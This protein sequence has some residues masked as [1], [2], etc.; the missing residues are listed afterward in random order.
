M[1]T[2][3]PPQPRQGGSPGRSEPV[4][5]ARPFIAPPGSTRLRW[6]LALGALAL[7]VGTVFYLWNKF[8]NKDEASPPQ[9]PPVA[10]PAFSPVELNAPVSTSA[11]GLFRSRLD[12]P[13]GSG[14]SVSLVDYDLDG[15][16]DVFLASNRKSILLEN[17]GE[18]LV[19]VSGDLGLAEPTRSGQWADFDGDGDL[20]LAVTSTRR[21]AVLFRR[22]G[23][24]FTRIQLPIS[25][26]HNPEG[27][28]WID[29]DAD[30]DPDL[31]V[32]NGKMGVHL[33]ENEAGDLRDVSAAAGFGP[34]GWGRDNGDFVHFLDF[35]LDGRVDILYA[36]TTGLAARNVDGQRFEA[37]SAPLKF[38][39]IN[40]SQKQAMAMGDIDGDRD[41]DVFAPQR[42]G[43]SLYENRAGEFAV[44]ENS[45]LLT[46]GDR[47]QTAVFGDVDL[48]GDLDL[49]IALRGGGL[50]LFDN[51]NGELHQAT[52]GS[53]F[54]ESAATIQILGMALGDIDGDGDSDLVFQV[55]R[56]DSGILLNSAAPPPGRGL[57][58]TRF[59]RPP[60]PGTQI[61][62]RSVGE[63]QWQTRILGVPT[64][65]GSQQPLSPMFS[66]VEGHALIQ[67]ELTD[68]RR[69]CLPA[70]VS[71]ASTAE[72][73]IDDDTIN[74][75]KRRECA[76]K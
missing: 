23:A 60:V 3:S 17:R 5:R 42:S 34:S 35:D 71:A 2:V 53:G 18:Q 74:S 47:A 48:D 30:G 38:A 55:L 6:A 39:M 44:V 8:G 63:H 9:K 51:R 56:G 50:E 61:A 65:S 72:V 43:A 67:I 45:E 69:V 32:T 68:G 19:A 29:F 52:P 66:L 57:L 59:A 40:G 14:A 70:D 76:A 15:D 75:A 46:L 12:L 36:A 1:S 13:G 27:H 21:T 26:P 25:R 73:I 4:D 37:V 54:G 11:A 28:G 41:L 20:D 22:E 10:S 58:R 24:R 49:V 31:L 64:N 62:V 16:L 7:V 33:F